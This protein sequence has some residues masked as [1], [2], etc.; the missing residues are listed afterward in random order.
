MCGSLG[1]HA[2]PVTEQRVSCLTVWAFAVIRTVWP[3]VLEV[4][5]TCMGLTRLLCWS[6][7]MEP[8]WF[9]STQVLYYLLK[10]FFYCVTALGLS[11]C[12]KACDC[13]REGL[14]SPRSSYPAGL[15]LS[16][17]S[18]KRWIE[19]QSL[20]TYIAVSINSSIYLMSWGAT[21]TQQTR[22][23][24]Q[25]IHTDKICFLHAKHSKETT[26]CIWFT[27]SHKV[28]NSTTVLQE[29]QMLWPDVAVRW[30]GKNKVLLVL[31]IIQWLAH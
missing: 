31:H 6:F 7:L 26:T 8:N 17:L 1:L 5:Y 30:A 28:C 19:H 21:G 2:M 13:L 15:L 11:C 14:H 18:P 25:W 24:V 4:D 20:I 22:S 3:N 29:V 27:Q 10:A 9:A 23:S 12:P 16:L